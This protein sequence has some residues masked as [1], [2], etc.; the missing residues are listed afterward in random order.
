MTGCLK[1]LD[2]LWG[3]GGSA[4]PGLD[5][6]AIVFIRSRNALEAIFTNPETAIS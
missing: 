4:D 1:T 2:R 3:A 6:W 5:M